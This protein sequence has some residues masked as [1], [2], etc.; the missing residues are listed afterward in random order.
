MPSRFRFKCLTV[1]KDAPFEKIALV[2][3]KQL[4]EIGVDMDIEALSL[5]GAGRAD[6]RPATSTPS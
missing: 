4:Y 3:Q 6:E 1:A 2:L 5:Q